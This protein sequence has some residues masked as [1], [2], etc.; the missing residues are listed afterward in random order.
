MLENHISGLNAFA[1]KFGLKDFGFDL[2][3][4]PYSE[5]ESNKWELRLLGDKGRVL[6]F[7]LPEDGFVTFC[8]SPEYSLFQFYLSHSIQVQDFI[9]LFTTEFSVVFSRILEEAKDVS[10][11]V[12]PYV[13]NDAWVMFKLE[14]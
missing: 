9:E 6:S 13:N 7:D 2:F 5:E 8:Y 3:E 14:I 10:Y 11:T 1:N 12:F 4:D